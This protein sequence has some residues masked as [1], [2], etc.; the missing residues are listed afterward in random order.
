MSPRKPCQKVRT[1]RLS[2]SLDSI[3]P[4]WWHRQ[5]LGI[6][7]TDSQALIS[8]TQAP[9]GLPLSQSVASLSRP[10][11]LKCSYLAVNKIL[12]GGLPR[13][14]ILEISGPPGSFKESLALDFVR[15]FAEFNEG[16]MFVGEAFYDISTPRR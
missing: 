8:A 1:P 10:N 7:I 3:F 13:G 5:E 4:R 11:I 15:I 16:V 12:G 14:H 9:R 2:V 6:D